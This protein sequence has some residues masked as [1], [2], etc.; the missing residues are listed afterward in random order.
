MKSYKFKPKIKQ[1]DTV[2][3]KLKQNYDEIITKV[4]KKESKN[5]P[6]NDTNFV[7]SESEIKRE[8]SQ[9]FHIIFHSRTQSGKKIG[10]YSSITDRNYNDSFFSGINKKETNRHEKSIKYVN[11]NEENHNKLSNFNNTMLISAPNKKNQNKI[12]SKKHFVKSGRK[13]NEESET[14]HVE[15]VMSITKQPHRSDKDLLLKSNLSNLVIS[16]NTSSNKYNNLS[17]RGER[18]LSQEKITKVKSKSKEKDVPKIIKKMQ[19]N[20]NFISNQ[21]KTKKKLNKNYSNN[22]TIK[23][24]Q[25]EKKESEINSILKEHKTPNVFSVNLSSLNLKPK[26]ENS[27]KDLI[28]SIKS[29]NINEPNKDLIKK[30]EESNLKKK[31]HGL[32]IVALDLISDKENTKSSST[33]NLTN[34]NNSILPTVRTGMFDSDSENNDKKSNSLVSLKEARK[35]KHLGTRSLSQNKGSYDSFSKLE[36][37]TENFKKTCESSMNR[38]G[39]TSYFEKSFKAADSNRRA[40]E[41]GVDCDFSSIR[42]YSIDNTERNLYRSKTQEIFKETRFKFKMDKLIELE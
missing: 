33:V 21:E 26:E 38:N 32:K 7:K 23:N 3:I 19:V 17:S 15:R 9:K 29:I 13:R 20:V 11:L 14:S 10:Y 35:N 36:K 8:D 12:D 41:R 4:L 28:K 5:S 16:Y 18:R 22:S 1:V 24:S 27:N 34:V 6:I 31:L 25:A 40:S 30:I 39:S 2:G 42:T 37:M